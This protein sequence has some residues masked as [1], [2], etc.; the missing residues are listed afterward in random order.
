[1]SWY[2]PLRNFTGSRRK[3]RRLG[4]AGLAWKD[5]EH[6]EESSSRTR[7]GR[8]ALQAVR[9]DH[10]SALS[11]DPGRSG[12]RWGCYERS[13]SAVALERGEAGDEGQRDPVDLPGVG[14]P[15]PATA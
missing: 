5:E 9:S 11:P 7:T 13:V 1:M 8:R 3:G 2:I 15:L 10:P 4:G 12:S 14:E 6:Q